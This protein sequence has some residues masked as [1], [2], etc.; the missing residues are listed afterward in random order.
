M[1]RSTT[2][3]KLFDLTAQWVQYVHVLMPS[4]SYTQGVPGVKAQ[5]FFKFQSSKN[6]LIYVHQSIEKKDAT[7]LRVVCRS[8]RKSERFYHRFS[9]YYRLE[10]YLAASQRFYLSAFNAHFFWSISKEH[11]ART[12]YFPQY[13]YKTRTTFNT[14]VF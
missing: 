1:Y 3:H 2:R 14:G 5:V 12:D 4:R 13:A 10:L 9:S 8:K 11:W 7:L 6:F